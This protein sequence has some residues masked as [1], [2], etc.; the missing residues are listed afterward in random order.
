MGFFMVSTLNCVVNREIQVVGC[1]LWK[2]LR[3]MVPQQP[4]KICLRPFFKS[5]FE[6]F[7]I[8]NSKFSN[9][10]IRFLE[11]IEILKIIPISA[12]LLESNV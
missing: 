9:L 8:K 12:F 7:K 10:S 3:V 2:Y 5:I 11:S 4:F 1:N 6:F